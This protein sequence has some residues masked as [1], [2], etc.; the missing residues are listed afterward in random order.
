MRLALIIVVLHILHRSE[1]RLH[2][3][4]EPLVARVVDGS[5]HGRGEDVGFAVLV[6]WELV[7]GLKHTSRIDSA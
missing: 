2:G 7:T 4:I 5:A 6:G 3:D 1:R